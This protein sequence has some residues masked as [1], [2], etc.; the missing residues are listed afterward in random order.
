MSLSPILKVKY[1]LY[2]PVLQTSCRVLGLENLYSS[3]EIQ[4]ETSFLA[5]HVNTVFE[6]R[7]RGSLPV[8]KM[9]QPV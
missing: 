8:L 7:K 3:Q 6:F 9:L 4:L 5:N 2:L 1:N